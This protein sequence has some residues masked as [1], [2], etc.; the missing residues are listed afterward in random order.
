MSALNLQE[1]LSASH[2]TPIVDVRTPAEF[3]QG[4]IPGALNIPLFTNEE[5]SEIGTLYKQE[6]REKAV[7]RGL[8]LIG[9]RMASLSR[10]GK[11]IATNNKLLI[12]CWRGGMRSEKMSW[13][14]ELVGLQCLVLKGGF[15]AY[16]NQLLEDFKDLKNMIVLQ[17][18]TIGKCI[19]I[20]II[21]KHLP[22]CSN[23]GKF[24]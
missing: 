11:E 17:G 5:R 9:P 21:A 12:H 3:S 8:E 14:F 4:H 18:L 16:R 24:V 1:F 19:D 13:L 15:K 7:E 22:S 10:S 2:E 20:P 23:R 6:S